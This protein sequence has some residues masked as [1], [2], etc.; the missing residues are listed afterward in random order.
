VASSVRPS[1][2]PDYFASVIGH[3]GEVNQSQ[4]Q[5]PSDHEDYTSIMRFHPF[6]F[7]HF[8]SLSFIYHSLFFLWQVIQPKLQNV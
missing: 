4:F 8:I 5:V 2:H 3:I 6:F 7:C 1:G